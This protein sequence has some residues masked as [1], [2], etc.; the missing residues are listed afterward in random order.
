MRIWDHCDFHCLNLLIKT[1]YLS[2]HMSKQMSDQWGTPKSIID[3]L[4][5]GEY[6]DP[7]PHE[8]QPICQ[9]FVDNN[10][11]KTVKIY[12]RKESYPEVNGL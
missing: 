1:V 11:N 2:E 9:L 5:A 8:K 6:F 12:R 10:K 7:C 3:L 4:P